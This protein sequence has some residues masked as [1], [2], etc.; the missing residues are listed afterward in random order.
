[1]TS[2][3]SVCNDRKISYNVTSLVIENIIFNKMY[4]GDRE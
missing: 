2:I 4:N 3:F 1:M